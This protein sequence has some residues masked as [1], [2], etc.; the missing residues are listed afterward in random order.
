MM[1]EKTTEPKEVRINA[2]S[3]L[4]GISHIMHIEDLYGLFKT[5]V[6]YKT[7]GMYSKSNI[8]S[9]NNGIFLSTRHLNMNIFYL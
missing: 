2:L 5:K 6:Q 4:S 7:Y 9:S 3:N 8:I 1:K